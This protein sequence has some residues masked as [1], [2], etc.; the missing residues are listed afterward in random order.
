MFMIS[1]VIPDHNEER[2]LKN[3]IEK[4]LVFLK[5]NI[6]GEF[7]IIISDNA[8]TDKTPEIAKNLGEKFPEVKYL[9]LEKKGK[10]LAIFEG[11]QFASKSQKL[12]FQNCTETRF[13]KETEFRYNIQR[14]PSFDTNLKKARPVKR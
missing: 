7:Q 8:S 4:L 11:W 12:G 13:P 9:R 14:K 5:S 3:N 2:I 6:S 1:V 10:G